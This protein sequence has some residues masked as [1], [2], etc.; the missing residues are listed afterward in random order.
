[1]CLQLGIIFDHLDG[2]VARYRRTF[3]KLG[4]FYDKVSDMVTWSAIMLVAG[5]QV[6]RTSGEPYYILLAASSA[7][8]MN[9]MGY[10]KWLAVAEAERVRW[11]EARKDPEVV[12]RRTAPIV[13]APPPQR[14][15]RE[16]VTWFLKRI[17]TVW[18]FDEMDLWFWLGLALLVGRLDLGV[19]LLAGSQFVNMFVMIAIRARE[20]MRADERIAALEAKT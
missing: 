16:W 3:T 5:W 1:V 13:I 11:L 9:V 20:V 4:S 18:K 12:A 15:R 14:T 7:V 6:Y 2:T 19:W 10:I 17:S 8:A